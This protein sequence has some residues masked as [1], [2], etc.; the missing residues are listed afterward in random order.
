MID[1]NGIIDEASLY[2]CRSCQKSLQ[3]KVLPPESLA[4]YRWIGPVPPELQDL[5]WMKELLIARAHLTGHIVHLQ[6]RNSAS[7]F[8]LK[9]HV[10]LL[11][12]DTMKLLTIL[13]L[14]PSNL[15][16]KVRIVWVGK[17]VRDIDGLR[18]C[19][20][21]RTHKIYDALIWLIQNNEDYKEVTIDH[22]QFE[23]WPPVWVAENLL[24]LAGATDDGGREDNARIGIATEDSDNAEM[25]PGDVPM[26]GLGII[27]TAAVSEPAQLC[28]IQQI[29]LLKSDRTINVLTGNNI[30]NVASYFTSAFPSIFPWGTGKHID[31]RR[32]QECKQK[33]EFRRWIQLLLTNSSRY[34]PELIKR[35]SIRCFQGHRGFVVL[36]F[37]LLRR[38]HNL[39]KMNL[40]T[41]KDNWETTR[42]LLESLTEE[43]LTT[44]AQEAAKHKPISDTAVKKLLAMVNTIGTKDPGSEERK[45]HLLARLKS[46]TVYHGLPQIFITLNPA[47]NNSPIALF[48]AG[49]R[50][51]VKSFHPQLYTVGHR[52][53]TM[54][55]NPLSVVEYFR[56]TID[57]ILETMLKGGMFGELIHYH[58]PIEYQGRGTPHAHLVVCP[59][60]PPPHRSDW[61]SSG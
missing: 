34:R 56:N 21:V 7:H 19:F 13:P 15:P 26:T 49:E 57:T 58:G 46:A 29:S 18:D 23:R 42:P 55:D 51:D 52:L 11:P 36:C 40:I 43:R 16:D 61:Y 5:T 3:A 6:D 24:D 47:D 39:Q 28:A 33:L 1:P 2:I 60:P 20:S 50:I 45:S 10:I 4:N 25:A 38:R 31:P 35:T 8:S 59:S 22:S 12:Q 41:S 30:L 27:D 9:G 44:T 53:K 54:L 48:Y 14:L 17:P 32:S 37:N